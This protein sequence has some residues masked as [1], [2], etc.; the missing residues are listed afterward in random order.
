M[1]PKTSI[2]KRHICQHN[3]GSWKAIDFCRSDAK[4]ATTA[5][6]GQKKGWLLG[7]LRLEPL[8]L[9]CLFCYVRRFWLLIWLS[10]RVPNLEGSIR[11]LQN[12]AVW[13]W[14]LN[15]SSIWRTPYLPLSL[16]SARNTLYAEGFGYPTAQM[17][18]LEMSTPTV[19]R[20]GRDSGETCRPVDTMY[21]VLLRLQTLAC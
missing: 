20:H 1:H 3:R 9:Y 19:S 10:S 4:W 5:W 21:S 17:L 12:G 11:A 6:G 13:I 14:N 18:S 2:S 16:C 8:F 7:T 15:F